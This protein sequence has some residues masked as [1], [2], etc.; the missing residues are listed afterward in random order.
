MKVRDF[1]VC[2]NNTDC[3]DALKIGCSYRVKESTHSLL[4]LHDL[5]G[6]AALNGWHE[7]R[8]IRLGATG[9]ISKLDRIIFNVD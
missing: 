6:P 8:F 4:I 9:D 3:Y 1:V 7:H 2:I 5:N